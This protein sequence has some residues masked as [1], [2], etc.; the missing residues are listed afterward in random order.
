MSRFQTLYSPFTAAKQDLAGWFLVQGPSGR[1]K[2]ELRE[3]LTARLWTCGPEGKGVGYKPGP[4]GTGR[5]G[6][7]VEEE[8]G[9]FNLST[10]FRRLLDRLVPLQVFSQFPTP[11]LTPI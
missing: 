8:G 5:G 11:T 2:S 1:Q 6:G 7:E 4:L 9:P 10:R 3:P